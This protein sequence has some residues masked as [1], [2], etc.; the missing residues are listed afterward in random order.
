MI[1]YKSLVDGTA[2]LKTGM[3]IVEAS[4][5]VRKAQRNTGS[6][7]TFIF[8]ACLAEA[9]KFQTEHTEGINGLT[10]RQRAAQAY[11]AYYKANLAAGA[12]LGYSAD[13]LRVYSNACR[14]LYNALDHD[15]D[16]LETNNATGETLL[17]S[18]GKIEQAV[19]KAKQAVEDA[20]TEAAALEKR[21]A[22]Q[23]PTLVKNG[24]KEESKAKAEDNPLDLLKSSE[25]RERV[26]DLIVNLAELESRHSEAENGEKAAIGL[27]S[28]QNNKIEKLL[29]GKFAAVLN[30]AKEAAA[31]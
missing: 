27:I 12:G 31:A 28:F 29:S 4:V 21:A 11:Q 5:L 22:G 7:E 20:K 25:L 18:K 2:T 3:E 16:L 17:G 19:K 10:A 8:R 15:L 1:E 23:A 9:Q 13:D 26:E 14:T 24:D 30:A 6:A